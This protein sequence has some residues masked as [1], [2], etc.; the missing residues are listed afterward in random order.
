M[1][2]IKL[3]CPRCSMVFHSALRP[4]AARIDCPMCGR[5][6]AVPAI[7]QGFCTQSDSP[8]W[9]YT[10]GSET[11]GP[12]SVGQLHHLAAVGRLRPGD[13]VRRDGTRRWRRAGSI[14]GLFAKDWGLV[15]SP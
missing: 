2:F 12:V 9:F 8:L 3:I 6:F 13:L 1:S 11:L 7:A 10:Q 4:S 5:V 14:R 15:G